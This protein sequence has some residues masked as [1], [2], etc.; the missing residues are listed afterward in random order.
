MKK[1]EAGSRDAFPGCRCD[2]VNCVT[3]NHGDCYYRPS[4]CP[5]QKASFRARATI[6]ACFLMLFSVLVSAQN[7]ATPNDKIGL[8]ITAADAPTA[9]A[10]TWRAYL[11]GSATPTVLTG[12]VCSGS[13]PVSCQFPIPATF[14]SGSHNVT[15]TAGNAAGEGPKSTVFAFVLTRVPG[16][17][18][19]IRII[20]VP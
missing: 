8:D 14:P 1:T 2:C 11:D 4:I 10:Y 19:N 16:Q 20:V 12:A 3:G 18:V 7:A 6:G 17:P 15:I 13:A 9:A 5:A